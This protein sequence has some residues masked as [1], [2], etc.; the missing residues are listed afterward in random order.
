MRSDRINFLSSTD[1]KEATCF[2]YISHMRVF[3][4]GNRANRPGSGR[5]IDSTNTDCSSSTSTLSPIISVVVVV[6]TEQ[7]DDKG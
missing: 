2:L 6:P 4:M 5:H 7:Q 1:Q 3:L